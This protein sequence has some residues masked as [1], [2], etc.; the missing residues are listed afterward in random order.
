MYASLVPSM[1]LVIEHFREVWDQRHVAPPK[2][3]KLNSKVI[4]L[5]VAK[6]DGDSFL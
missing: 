5:I 6:A 3:G 4:I 2:R 1:M